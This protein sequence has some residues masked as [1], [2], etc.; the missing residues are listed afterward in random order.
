M[1]TFFNTRRSFMTTVVAS[2][3]LSCCGSAVVAAPESIRIGVAQ[4]GGGEPITWGGSPA[5]VARINQWLEQEFTPDGI[6]VEWIFFKGAGPAVN[7]ALSNKQIDFAYQ[8][9]LPAVIG[10]SNGLKTKILLIAGARN[11]LY[12]VTPPGSDIQSVE[13]L[14]GK[15]VAIFRGTNGHLVANNI[16]AAHGLTERELKGI[17]LD[18][19][20]TQAAI[21]SKGVDAAFGGLE[22]FK[23]RDQGIAQFVYSTQGKDPALTRQAHFLV[24]EEFAVEN[25]QVVQRVVDVLVRAADWSS[26][27]TNRDALFKLWTKSG[28]PYATYAAE[29]DNQALVVRHSPLV[30]DFIVAR[31]KAVADDAL[32]LKLI[33]KEVST[34]GWFDTSYLQQALDKQGLTNRWQGYD[35]TGNSVVTPIAHAHSQKSP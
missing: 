12:L 35:Q 28:V 20:S 6:K 34:D 33:R 10:R 22:F 24:R 18:I 23:L 1:T 26:H 11:N 13:D 31:Y 4:A 2:L 5:S 15:K 8:G 21:A 17:N 16:L 7:E 30:D 3:I 27:E 29:F 25:K 14:K 9:D 32:K 19:G